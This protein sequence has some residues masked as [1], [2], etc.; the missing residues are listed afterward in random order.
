MARS[1][2][3]S[4]QTKQQNT[5]A[6]PKHRQRASNWW[7]DKTVQWSLAAILAITFIAYIPALSGE[8]NN[9]DD[10]LYVT[11]SKLIQDISPSGLIKIFS[12]EVAANYHPLTILS[13]A[14]N[15]Q[16][17]GLS[18]FSYHLFNVLLHLLN[19]FLVFYFT[20][21]LTRRNLTIA[22]VASLFFGIHPMH[23]ESVAWVSER[24]DVLYTCFFLAAMI[25]YLK[26]LT[27]FAAKAKGKRANPQKYY[28]YTLLFFLFSLLSKGMAVV[29]P[30]VLLGIDFLKK[31]RIQKQA[32]L[33]KLPFFI[34]ALLFGITA[35]Y[36]QTDSGAVSDLGR[37]GLI[38][39]LG[40]ASYG[41]L[42][43]IAK[44]FLPIHLS[45][46]HPY[47]N[48]TG[49]L[50]PIFWIAPLGVAAL[51]G[52]AIYTL[53]SQRMTFF[54][55]FFYA[56]TVALV[57]QFITVGSAL[58]AERYT[59]L[60]Y[61]GLLLILGY[62]YHQLMQQ[63]SSSWALWRNIA[64]GILGF[65]ALIFTYQTFERCKVWK[66][67]ETLW[68]D[69]MLKYPKDP[70]AY[71]SRGAY[72]SNHDQPE[73]A[74]KDYEKALSLMPNHDMA[75]YNLGNVY[76]EQKQYELALEAYARALQLKPKDAKVFMN[77]GNVYRDMKNNEAAMA[78]YNQAIELNP[79]HE[80]YFNRGI[81]YGQMGQ[82][83][84]AMEDYNTAISL[85]PDFA[86]VYTNRGNIYFQAGQVDLAMADY[87][88]SISLNPEYD[89]AYGNR[90][91][92]YF[93]KKQYDL[94]I[95]DFDKAI[96]LDEK[97]TDALMNRAATYMTLQQF[98]KA[99]E[100]LT[101]YIELKPDN[102]NVSAYHWRGQ[103]F[104]KLQQYDKALADLNQLIALQPNQK[105]FYLTRADILQAMGRNEEAAADKLKG[106]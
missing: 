13:L 9:W 2:K 20:Y 98:D 65:A 3:K 42:Y 81:L 10:Q 83:D 15:Y 106:N 90:G 69:V 101:T 53:K 8:F 38:S 17:S 11:D 58:V 92:A 30:V 44:L 77:R 67:S 97:Y 103:A 78:D 63:K 50:T 39:R 79:N 28:I 32:I 19:V 74:Q 33:E 27:H 102:F 47:P 104:F 73:K 18:P 41:F 16:I 54:G 4:V 52:A 5:S 85:K 57:L 48:L 70:K 55:L 1:K 35:L 31:R 26:Y 14:I 96:E 95:Q 61:I 91:A 89:K 68:S 40:Y 71:N 72:Y 29:F 100:D 23:V 80:N 60:S 7:K 75:H 6:S 49:Q 82:S 45:S 24:K 56:I 84:K 46:Y 87:N 21:L 43:Y 22:A 64:T 36:I 94:A 62:G 37:F 88:Q 99:S 51:W 25:T 59:Y 105:A 66:N 93:Q 34:I 76:A 86:D 12:T